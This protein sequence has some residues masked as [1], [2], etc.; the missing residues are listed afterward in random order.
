M[1]SNGLYLRVIEK[2]WDCVGK[3]QKFKF[4]YE[5]QYVEHILQCLHLLI[6]E[7]VNCLEKAVEIYT[8]M[9]IIL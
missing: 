8:D 6:S 3:G 7:A 1:F 4:D 5:R 9:V 2:T